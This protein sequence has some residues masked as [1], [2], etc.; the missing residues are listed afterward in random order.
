[1][2][3]VNHKNS[4][5]ENL[6]QIFRI[7]KNISDFSYSEEVSGLGRGVAVQ[8]TFSSVLSHTLGLHEPFFL[9]QS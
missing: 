6:T 9:C 4:F 2:K 3:N 7:K 1:V 8:E 5:D